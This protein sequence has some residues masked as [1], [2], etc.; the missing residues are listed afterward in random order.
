MQA[1]R[2]RW[3]GPDDS[4][5]TD[6]P[7]PA[8]SR[9]SIDTPDALYEDLGPYPAY[10]TSPQSTVTVITAG[11]SRLSF[12]GHCGRFSHGSVSSSPYTASSSDRPSPRGVIH[13]RIPPSNSVELAYLHAVDGSMGMYDTSFESLQQPHTESSNCSVPG[14]HGTVVDCASTRSAPA[15]D[16]VGADVP[17]IT[18]LHSSREAGMGAV[19]EH[20]L[21]PLDD[22][23]R[24]L[25]AG[26]LVAPEQPLAAT[27]QPAMFQSRQWVIFWV[28]LVVMLSVHLG[29][30]MGE[31][32]ASG[33]VRWVLYSVEQLVMNGSALGLIDLSRR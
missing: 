10:D 7:L 27:E 31:K 21:A 13:D 3:I 14:L 15:L 24:P 17:V 28:F 18:D 26:S 20:M 1:F 29:Y 33:L 32:W 11:T 2:R 30:L 9:L 16:T 6:A 22:G 25:A 23:R 4:P 5:A 19:K 8:E 12:S